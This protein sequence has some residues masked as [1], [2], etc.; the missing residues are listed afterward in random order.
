MVAAALSAAP[1]KFASFFW[2]SIEL[3]WQYVAKAKE[4]MPGWSKIA[5][6]KGH[7]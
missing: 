7:I 3:L 1:L 6:I 4:P 5:S 2:N